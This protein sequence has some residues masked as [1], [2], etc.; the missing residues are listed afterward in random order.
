MTQE[1]A[2]DILKLGYNVYL[3]GPPGSGKT[4]LLNK[5]VAYLKKHKR[6]VAVTASTGIA[7]THM[8][9]RTIHS[10]S[11]MGIKDKISKGEMKKLLKKSYLQKIKET[12]VLIIDEIS[13]LH[14]FQFDLLDKIC[15]AFRGSWKPFGGIQI[16]CSGDFFQL[17]PVQKG[18]GEAGFVVKSMVW[19]N[20]E[21]KICYL[22]E[23]HRQEEGD[24]FT[25]LNYIRNN[26]TEEARELLINQDWEEKRSLIAPTKLY[27]HNVDVDNINNIELS[28]IKGPESVYRMK[29]KGNKRI[30]AT[31]IK[32][33]LAPQKLILKEGAEVMFIKNNFEDEYVNGT[34]GQVIGFTGDRFPIVETTQGKRITVKPASWAIEENGMFRAKIIQL[35]LRLAW[36][37]TVHKSQGMNLDAAEIDLSRSFV[38][39]M[40]YVALSRLR[41]LS[42][43]RLMGINEMALKVNDNIAEL[44]RE[45]KRTSEETQKVLEQ[46]E[47]KDKEEQQYSFLLSL[48][49]VSG[50]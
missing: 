40:G 33:C 35:P 3:T 17:P 22:D 26:Q 29:V 16:V 38:E 44:D 8:N 25:V 43:M 7:A 41:S 45:F 14:D 10:W 18:A 20:M 21:K 39:G 24:L 36:A 37:I 6:R 49:K 4:F 48:T 28:K 9:G 50:K 47:K 11:G 2:F 1:E 32:G 13:M 23:Q 12:D 42:G 5:Y 31:L 19:N 15:R 27:T 46:I 30:A 34:L